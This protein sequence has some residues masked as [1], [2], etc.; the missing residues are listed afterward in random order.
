M[1]ELLTEN[2]S[3]TLG[4]IEDF[5]VH[6]GYSPTLREMADFF[7]ITVGAINQRVSA[8]IKKGY[9]ARGAARK[10]RTLRPI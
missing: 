3:R 7:G 5:S 4:Y 10:A 6:H 1:G 8:L 9:I 2:Q